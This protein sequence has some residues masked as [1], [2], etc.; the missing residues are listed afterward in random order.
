[1]T[2]EKERTVGRG[3]KKEKK[4][5]EEEE[6]RMMRG[7]RNNNS[8]LIDG[9]GQL[10]SNCPPMT[11]DQAEQLLC[12]G[13]VGKDPLLRARV[14]QALLE[15]TADKVIKNYLTSVRYGLRDVMDQLL[16][17]IR[18]KFSVVCQTQEFLTL[19]LGIVKQPEND[20]ILT[21]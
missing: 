6:K 10:C 20:W 8:Y 1:M 13:A 9:C 16:E 21:P 11:G 5:E 18:G 17:A 15:V 14:E 7:Q 19:P 3:R 4:K 2:K 12:Y